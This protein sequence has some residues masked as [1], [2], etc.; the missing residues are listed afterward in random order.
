MRNRDNRDKR[1]GVIV[2]STSRGNVI[3]FNA[4]RRRDRNGARLPKPKPGAPQPGW[5]E[6]MADLDLRTPWVLRLLAVIA[7]LILSMLIL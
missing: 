7:I 5:V 6:R 1:K 4:F 2:S 3:D